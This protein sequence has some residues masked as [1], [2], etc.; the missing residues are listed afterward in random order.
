MLDLATSAERW[1]GF[2][3]RGRGVCSTQV[4]AGRPSGREGGAPMFIT[5]KRFDNKAQGRREG[6]APWVQRW[7]AVD[8]RFAVSKVGL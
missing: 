3:D 5:V 8:Y 1:N 4:K 2:D 7:L 6:G